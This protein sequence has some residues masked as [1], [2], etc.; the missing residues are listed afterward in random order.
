MGR[1][2]FVNYKYGDLSVYPIASVKWPE[3]TK[4]RDY[5]NE[6]QTH[7]ELNDH[8]NQGECD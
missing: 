3:I 8:I 5:V 4:V 7:L 6:L 1:R 2:I